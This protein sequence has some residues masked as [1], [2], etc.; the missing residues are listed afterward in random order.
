MP[1]WHPM[2]LNP[3]DRTATQT[4][5]ESL[6]LSQGKTVQDFRSNALTFVTVLLQRGDIRWGYQG[7]SHPCNNS[8]LPVEEPHNTLCAHTFKLS[9]TEKVRN[10]SLEGWLSPE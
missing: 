6:I 7:S 4:W 8:G 2:I 5:K 10:I 3:R 9:F 1:L